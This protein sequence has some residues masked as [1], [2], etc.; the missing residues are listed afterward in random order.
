MV[1]IKR[2]FKVKKNEAGKV[3]RNYIRSE[4]RCCKERHKRR[5]RESNRS[6][7]YEHYTENKKKQKEK[8]SEL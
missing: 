6:S 8:R 3:T 7:R 2:E 1:K 4:R 5:G